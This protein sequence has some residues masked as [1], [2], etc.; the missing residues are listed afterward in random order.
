MKI[1]VE[2][3]ASGPRLRCFPTR[4]MPKPRNLG[5]LALLFLRRN[6]VMLRIKNRL[7]IY[8]LGAALLAPSFSIRAQTPYQKPPKVVLDVLD[9]PESTLVSVSPSRD[10]MVLATPVRYPSI[11]EL[12]EPMLRLAG[13]RINPKTNGPHNPRRIVKLALKNIADGKETPLAAD[14]KSTR[15]N[16]SHLGI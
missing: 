8:L 1:G 14:R 15:L 13:S 10:K 12:A 4:L 5:P 3:S 16:S 9:A 7:I 2:S 6:Q 11:A